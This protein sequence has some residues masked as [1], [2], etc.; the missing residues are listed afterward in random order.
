MEIP[1]G[2]LQWVYYPMTL[3]LVI[4]DAAVPAAPSEV[5]VIG[6]GTLLANG[7]LILPLV[8]LAVML[9]SWLGDLLLFLLFQRG[10]NTWLN[11]YR[12]GR[13]ID[14]AVTLALSKA[15]E[16]ST[17]AAVVAARFIPGGRTAAVAASGL[18][19][20]PFKP[21][22][23]ASAAGS[24]LWAT[25]MVGLGFVAGRVSVFPFWVNILIGTLVGIVVGSMIAMVIGY[26]RR[27]SSRGGALPVREAATT[28]VPELG[29]E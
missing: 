24:A 25:W 10:I 7:E 21:F 18:A 12:W 26:R 1:E 19:D 3:L 28:A 6:G 16:S 22:L 8:F 4:L 2:P 17:Y 29:A 9:G 13:R 20:V 23:L 15:G 5:M 27:S 11:R 14:R